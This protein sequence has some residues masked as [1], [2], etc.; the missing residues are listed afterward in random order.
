[1]LVLS[2][3]GDYWYKRAEYRKKERCVEKRKKKKKVRVISNYQAT[4]AIENGTE[5]LS[6]CQNMSF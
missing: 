5:Y 6:R 1:M 2:D 4:S 3:S